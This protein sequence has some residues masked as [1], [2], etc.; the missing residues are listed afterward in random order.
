VGKIKIGFFSLYSF[1]SIYS[2]IVVVYSPLTKNILGLESKLMSK[3]LFCLFITLF[4]IFL[5]F[6]K[7]VYSQSKILINEFLIEPTPQVIE[8]INIGSQTIDISGWIIDDDGGSSSIFTIPQNSIIYPNSCLV[9]S[10]NF[11]LN[12]TSADSVRLIN[13]VGDVI[14]SF[15]YKLSSGSGVAYFRL[16][17]GENNWTTGS[18][19][20]GLFN[21][22]KTSCLLSPTSTS[23][24]TPTPS[25][26][27][28]L[29]ITPGF[30]T[31]TLVNPTEI[32]SS[33]PIPTI[34]PRL[35][36]TP[37]PTSY[38]NIYLSEVMIYP[39]T[40]EHEWVEFYNN[41]DFLVSLE[42]WYLDDLENGGS[43]P[44]LFSLEIPAK[45]LIVFELTSSVFN[46]DGDQIRLLDFN[47]I[48]KDSFEYT[49]SIKGKTYGRISLE[50]DEF[51]LQEPSKNSANNPCVSPTNKPTPA[52]TNSLTL[53]RTPTPIITLTLPPSLT[54]N[55]TT[56]ETVLQTERASDVN[57]DAPSIE[58]GTVL[59]AGTKNKPINRKMIAYVKGLASSSFF[60]SILNVFYIFHKMYKRLHEKN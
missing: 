40:E 8:I 6:L 36:P 10:S 5:Q 29:T 2:N 28:L 19:N 32:P 44:K 25:P 22:T 1:I 45:S 60:I 47:K 27:L 30:I 17:D 59:S 54:N 31:P 21:S 4:L 53:I 14:D 39:E 42:N 7:P 23:T 35:F 51:C 20:L 15:S 34:T 56:H 43:A 13:N 58:T 50:T 55:K 3:W 37:S 12:R 41:N 18:P 33:T 57:V 48:L 16:P 26:N 49:N 52:P 9:Y 24:L 46:N 11:Y 38:D